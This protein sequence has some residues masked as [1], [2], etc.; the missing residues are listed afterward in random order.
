MLDRVIAELALWGFRGGIAWLVAHETGLIAAE[1][2]AEVSRAL[3]H[4]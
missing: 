4:M 1:K 3:G 2:L